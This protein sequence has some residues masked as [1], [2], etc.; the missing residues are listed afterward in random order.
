MIDLARLD[1]IIETAL[2]E[3]LGSGDVTSNLTVEP[4]A[5]SEGIILSREEAIL[6]GM[7]VL[8]RVFL[9]ADPKVVVT[10]RLAEGEL[11]HPGEVI[12]EL[13]GPTRGILA[14]ERLALNFLQRLCAVATITRRFVEAVAGSEVRILDTRKTTPGLRELEKYAV[15]TGGGA[16]HRMGLYDGILIKE[17]HAHAAGG[18]GEALERVRSGLAGA[19]SRFLIV[20][21]VATEAQA[22]E[23]VTAGADRLLLDN[24]SPGE[25][26]RLVE[27]IR[28]WEGGD[29]QLE[30]S[31]GITLQNV[32]EYAGTGV[33]Y[34]SIGAL[35]HSAR[36]VDLSLLLR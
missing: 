6:A 2:A 20:V 36:A 8:E 17:N 28:N 7:P 34:I 4:H 31:G 10:P 15:R 19:G 30:A 33:D 35:T 26:A 13:T 21:E 32:A 22:H 27:K 29:L 11:M 14:G 1:R 5:E 9:H 18:V 25:M 3:D 24:L 12:A 16:N 23:A